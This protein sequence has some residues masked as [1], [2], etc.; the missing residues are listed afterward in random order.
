M[1]PSPE[2]TAAVLERAMRRAFELAKRGP[3][4]NENPQV[5]CVILDPD[6]RT[7][8]EGWHMGAGTPHAEAMALVQLPPEARAQA[9]D[10]TAVVSLEPCNHTGRTGPCAVALVEAGIGAVVFAA[11]DPGDTSSGGASTLRAAGVRVT[12]GLLELEARELLA[13]WLEDRRA[14]VS[15]DASERPRVVVKWAQTLDGRAA[16]AD[17]SS[18][19]ITGPISRADVHRRRAAA[20]AILVGTGTL[21]ADDPSLT[22][23]DPEGNLLVASSEQPVPVVLGRRAI[24]A[25]ARVRRHPAL[26]QADVAL[27]NRAHTNPAHTN[28]AHI[29]PAHAD[30]AHTNTAH[31]FSEPIHLDG[32]NLQ[33]DLA[34]LAQV[35][36]GSVFVEGGPRIVS[37]LLREGLV[38][39]LLIYVAPSLLG[40]PMLAVGDLGVSSMDG[41]KKLTVTETVQLGQD[42]LFRATLTAHPQSEHPQSTHPQSTSNQEAL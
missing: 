33:A 37:A 39:E 14:Q 17:G 7:V 29:N 1:C 13:P 9:A 25:D 6:G 19:W 22:A 23:R 27:A 16:A 26:M 42:V 8:S 10:L 32:T 18:Q 24:P 34:Y 21:L 41:I 40:G 20:D 35:G 36:I 15:T 11:A 3:S 2:L 38:D 30:P 31:V 12:A 28:P 4:P 5:G